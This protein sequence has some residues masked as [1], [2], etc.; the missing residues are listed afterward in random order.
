M[1]EW[2]FPFLELYKHDKATPDEPKSLLA[3]QAKMRREADGATV[4]WHLPATTPPRV[5]RVPREQTAVWDALRG[6]DVSEHVL[7][8]RLRARENVSETRR[9]TCHHCEDSRLPD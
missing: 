2:S 9:E 8:P 1:P 4:F 3:F 7:A 6:G 5:P